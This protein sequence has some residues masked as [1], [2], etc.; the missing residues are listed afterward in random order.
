MFYFFVPPV[1]LRPFDRLRAELV[2]GHRSPV[3]RLRRGKLVTGHR[4]P[5]TNSH[6]IPYRHRCRNRT[7]CGGHVG[8]GAVGRFFEVGAIR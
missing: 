8:D 1:T 4:S 5:V 2:T 6:Q 3:T 7:K